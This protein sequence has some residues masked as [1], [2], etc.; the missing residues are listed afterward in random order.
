MHT[1]LAGHLTPNARDLPRR[2][3]PFRLTV[4]LAASDSPTAAER[5]DLTTRLAHLQPSLSPVPEGDWELVVTVLADSDGAA[6]EYVNRMLGGH[7]QPWVSAWAITD[8]DDGR[9]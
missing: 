1:P 2:V 3:R 6:R 9:G 5:E 8:L 4:R 7:G